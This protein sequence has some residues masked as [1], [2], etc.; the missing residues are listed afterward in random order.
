VVTGDPALL[1][2]RGEFLR[3]AM[4]RERVAEDEILC[5]VRSSG[6]SEVGQVQAVVLETDGSFSVIAGAEEKEREP[7]SRL[8]PPG[9]SASP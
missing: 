6:I 8:G 7:L 2:Y 4:K 9:K 5:A 1:V 3:D